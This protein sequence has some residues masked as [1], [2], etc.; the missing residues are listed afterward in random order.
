MK[1]MK[2]SKTAII[3]RG[4]PC[5]GKTQLSLALLERI[6]GNGYATTKT[7]IVL[8]YGWERC[9]RLDRRYEELT[10][11]QVEHQHVVVIEICCGE[12]F[13]SCGKDT[14]ILDSHPGATRNPAE[15]V[16]ILK[17]QGRNVFSFLLGA[18]WPFMRARE[19]QRQKLE[20]PFCRMLYDLY[21]LSDWRDFVAKA[22]VQE[23]KLNME[24][25]DTNGAA[26]RIFK[27]IGLTCHDAEAP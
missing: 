11:A 13:F 14:W 23:T 16:G 5:G 26:D 7:P 18:S 6:K 25:L 3:L 8:D 21:S 24:E 17:G 19:E 9:Y 22:D 4:P 1:H 20:L 15:W 2:S 12:G 27:A 10:T